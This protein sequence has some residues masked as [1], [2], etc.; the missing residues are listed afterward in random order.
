MIMDVEASEQPK[1]PADY[2]ASN[3]VLIAFGQSSEKLDCGTAVDHRW[4]QLTEAAAREGGHNNPALLTR[5]P[6]PPFQ[7]SVAS[8]QG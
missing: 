4:M 6:W 1:Q 2:L 3:G 7:C 8:L 5:R